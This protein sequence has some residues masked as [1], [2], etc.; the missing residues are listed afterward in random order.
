MKYYLIAGEPSGDLHGA[1]LIKALAT[2]DGQAQFRAWGGPKMEQA[3]AHLVKH[4]KDLA[5][6]GFIEVLKNL[7]HFKRLL[8]A[9]QEDIEAWQPDVVVFIDFSGFN[10]RVAKRVFGTGI[11][12]YYYI[13]PKVWA[14]NTKRAHKVKALIKR[15]YVILPFEQAFYQQFN[16]QVYYVGNPLLDAVRAFTPNPAIRQEWGLEPNEKVIALLPGSR[17]QEVSKILPAMLEAVPAFK[18]Y[19][20]VLAG[21]D[22]LPQTLY[23]QAQSMGIKIVKGQTYD[24]LSIAHAALVT[25]GTATLE[26]ALFEVPQV[27]CYRTSPISYRIAKTLIKVDYISLVNLI[28]QKEVVPELIQGKLAKENLVKQ[29]QQIVQGAGRQEQQQGY[30]RIKEIMGNE[31]TSLQTARLITQHLQQDLAQ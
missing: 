25:S 23:A 20:F 6:M 12:L 13:S 15:M 19:T 7:K 5:I 9:C 30:A 10:M 27:V 8:K 26:T 21:V 28:A 24:L 4:Y 29:L 3:G 17:Y 31:K 1:N 22:H 14:W 2:H 11:P 16:Y 18:E